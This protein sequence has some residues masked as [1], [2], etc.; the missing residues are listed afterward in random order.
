MTATALGALDRDWLTPEYLANPYAHYRRLRLEAPVFWSET[1]NSWVL[2]RYDDVIAALRTPQLLSNAGRMAAMLDRLPENLR[3]NL[4]LLYEHYRAGLIFSDPPNHTRLRTLVNRAFSPAV[5][6]RLRSRIETLVDDLLDAVQG[7][8]AMDLV[9]DFAYPLPAAV[10]CALLGLPLTDRPLFRQWSDDIIGLFGAGADAARATRGQASL[11]HFRDYLHHL[12]V[13]R[14]KNPGEDIISALI[15]AHERDDRLSEAELLSTSVTLLTAS[16]ETT[17]S[18]IGNGLLALLRHPDQLRR[19]QAEPALV[20][21]AL[22][23]LLRYD[24]PV[25]RQLRLATE[26]FEIGHQRIRKGEIVSPFLGAANRD[27]AQFPDP[28]RLDITRPDN[29]HTAFGYGIHFCVGAPVARVEVAIALT[30][31]LRRLPGIRL[32]TAAPEF[33]PDVTVRGL[34][35]LPVVF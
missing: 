9:Q 18:L 21:G 29:R 3:T 19:L 1:L 35:T 22:E 27:P 16:Q 5:V 11:R 7:A 24:S 17:T 8:G 6:E 4:D 15:V 31:L 10:A 32:A 12:I 13:A 2:T 30:T 33:K 20:K 28:D 23:E 14:R 25:Q 26:D 34:K